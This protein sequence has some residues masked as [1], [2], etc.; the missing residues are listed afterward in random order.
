MPQFWPQKSAPEEFSIEKLA[1]SYRA[2]LNE[3]DSDSKELYINEQIYKDKEIPET[4]L[5]EQV[6]IVQDNLINPQRNHWANRD[7]KE[8]YYAA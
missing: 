4:S 6:L 1:K 7:F 3:V 2:K 8:Y 5:Q